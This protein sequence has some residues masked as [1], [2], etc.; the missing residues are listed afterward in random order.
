MMSQLLQVARLGSPTLI[1]GDKALTGLITGKALALFTYLAVSGQPHT[2]D[3]L[4]D[5]LWSEFDNQQARNNL[6]YL[7]PDLRQQIEAYLMITPQTIGFNRQA[8]YW[9]DVEILQTTL[10]AQV[11]AARQTNAGPLNLPA[12]QAAL[13]LYQGKFLAGF[14]VRNAPVFEAWVR[15]QENEIHQLAVRGFYTLA[16]AYFQQG[17][18]QAG[19]R[20]NQQLLQWEPW[21]EAGHRLQMRLLVATGQRSAALAQY[22]LCRQR[23][24]DELEVEPEAATTALYEEIRAGIYDKK[25]RREEDKETARQELVGRAAQVDQAAPTTPVT[26]PPSR[27]ATPSLPHNLPGELTPFVGRTAEIDQ[28][29]TLLTDPVHFLITLTG[30]GGSGKTRLALAVAQ[31]ILDSALPA[32]NPKSHPKGL[33]QHL[34][35]GDGIWFVPLIGVADGENLIDRLAVVILDTLQ[36]PRLGPLAPLE[37]LIDALSNRCLLLILD[38]FE[39]LA[40]DVD[41][42][43]TILQ[44]TTKVKLLVTSRQTLNL[45]AEFVWQLDGLATPAVAAETTITPAEA[46]HYDSVALFV[47]RAQRVDR[48]F[49]LEQSNLAD[50]LRICHFVNGLPLALELAAAMLRHNSC[51]ELWQRLRQDYTALAVAQRDLPPR[52]RT[53]TALFDYSW[54]FLTAEQAR[55]LAACTVFPESFTAEAATVVAETT[56]ATLFALIDQSLL[57]QA[58]DGRFELHE[59]VRQYAA[60]QLKQAP[61][62]LAQVRQRQAYYYATL[63]EPD[64]AE[65]FRS[66]TKINFIQQE[67]PNLRVAWFWAIEAQQGWPICRM[68]QGLFVHFLAHGPIQEGWDLCNMALTLFQ[69]SAPDALTLDDISFLALALAAQSY[70]GYY[71]GRN[72][73]ADQLAHKALAIAEPLANGLAQ[74]LAY[75]ALGWTAFTKGDFT[76]QQRLCQKALA[77]AYA[78]DVAVM[79]VVSLAQ[80]GFVLALQGKATE[81]LTALYEAL[82]LIQTERFTYLEGYVLGELGFVYAMTGDWALADG[83]TQQALQLSQ[84]LNNSINRSFQYDRLALAAEALGDYRRALAWT[85]QALVFNNLDPVNQLWI[86]LVRSRVLRYLDDISQAGA[87]C[88]QAL[89][90]AQSLGRQAESAQA[91]IELG[92]VALAQQ[93]WQRAESHYYAALSLTTTDRLSCQAAAQAGLAQVQWQQNRRDKARAWAEQCYQRLLT[94]AWETAYDALFAAV[95]CYQVLAAAHDARAHTILQQAYDWVAAQ[96]LKISDENLRRS[97]LEKPPYHHQLQALLRLAGDRRAES[98]SN[99]P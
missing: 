37:Q 91:Q 19:L 12:F 63:V 7:L 99:P 2:R 79:V 70:W 76:E 48:T 55:T 96:S 69:R 77:V 16:E 27:P 1:L 86:L 94:Q 42:I 64:A 9:L 38:N 43:Y 24:A 35:F 89:A 22:T 82:Q 98:T 46:Q 4:A 10:A 81:A 61:Q 78:N 58:G 36:L 93:Q 21:H 34:K 68:S 90:L 40:A 84:G 62:R 49:R 15:Q 13:H 71:L 73:E 51:H 23:L 85:D 44:R 20:T 59:L 11:T 41:F 3:H 87:A 92:H 28:L 18:I 65:L 52:H 66:P 56:Q 17:E 95:T 6:R 97:F 47:E 29:Y 53:M 72:T 32:D 14:T 31:R 45:Q 88:Q 50:V 67:L 83:T 80:L 39:H 26:Q 57:T 30:L 60:D 5:L 33:R 25:R 74:A 8:P 54:R 75:L